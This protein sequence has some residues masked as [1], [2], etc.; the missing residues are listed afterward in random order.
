MHGRTR[1]VSR[2]HLTI[3]EEPEI[4]G[5]PPARRIA[6][7]IAAAIVAILL[8]PEP[9]TAAAATAVHRPEQRIAAPTEEP[10]I[11]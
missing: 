9:W 1:G 11:A 3:V 8:R 4:V 7:A 10:A 6:A 5:T 2:A